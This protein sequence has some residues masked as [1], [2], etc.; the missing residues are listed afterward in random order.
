M[1]I[2]LAVYGMAWR[3]ASKNDDENET[4]GVVSGSNVG[5]QDP[6]IGI[7]MKSSYETW[8]KFR[9]QNQGSLVMN[10]MQG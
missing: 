7:G 4:N 6:G 8:K 9:K 5:D 3:R 2:L 1:L 10:W